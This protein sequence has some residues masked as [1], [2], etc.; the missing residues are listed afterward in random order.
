MIIIF[1]AGLLFLL[2]TYVMNTFFSAVQENPLSTDTDVQDQI[3]SVAST[4]STFSHTL[5]YGIIILLISL[6]IALVI[7]SFLIPSHP[8]FLAV[9]VLG[10]FI[11][12]LISMALSNVFG[13]IVAGEGADT[14]GGIANQ[15]PITLYVIQYLPYLSVLIITIATIVM[16]SKWQSGA[17]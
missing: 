8:I 4:Y 16:F 10:V 7:T 15:Y 6:T 14:F 2:F 1:F 13:E 5:D 9:N 3:A 12:V 17:Q 11:L